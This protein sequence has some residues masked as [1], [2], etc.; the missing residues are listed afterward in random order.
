[1]KFTR[2]VALLVAALTPVTVLAQTSAPAVV[3]PRTFSWSS[4]A[5]PETIFWPAT[6]WW[7][8]G[9]L[10][11]DV[12]RRQLADMK[13]HDIRN[14]LMFP[15][16][17]DFRPGD[18]H[19]NPDYLTPEF[20]NRV[21]IVIGEATR[22]G[23]KLWAFVD[24]A[25]PPGFALRHHPQYA[26]QYATVQMVYNNG[27]W[28]ERR[29]P[30][31]YV[32]ADLLSPQTT[33]AFQAVTH[34]PYVNIAGS[35]FGS[36]LQF[37]FTD[38]PAYEYVK[39]GQSI[40]WTSGGDATFQRRFGYSALADG[41]LDAFTVTDVKKLTAAQKKVRGDVFDFLSGQFRD[42]YF[43]RERD[44]CR[45]N[46]GALCGHMGGE[47]VT[48][49]AAHF[50]YGSVMRQLR[51][52]DMPGVDA[53][54]RDIFPGQK[55]ENNFP[56][57]A[58]S[59]AHQN[60][61]ALSFTESFAVYG[62]GLT[63]AQM[64]W[65]LDY[66]FVRGINRY[67]AS[68]YPITTQDNAMTG[69]RPR[70]GPVEPMWDYLPAFH[71]YTARLGYTLAC[72]QPK[73]DIGLYYPVR[74]IWANG[75]ASDPAVR[76]FN[77]LTQALLE[78]QCDYDMIDDDILG[79]PATRVENGRLMLGA[80]SYRT[81]VV[82]PTAWM[83]DAAKQR[84]AA[85]E[86]AG[87]QVV[88]INDVDQINTAIAA[89]TPTIELSTASAD[90]R[91]AERCWTGGGAVFLFNEGQ[92]PYQG[93]VTVGLVG[94]LYL[95][96]PPTG[97][98]RSLNHT[99][100]PDGRAA[101]PLSLAAGESMLLVAQPAQ[102]TPA[103]SAPPIASAVVQSVTLT[104]GWTAHVDRQ[105]VVGEHDFE[106]HERESPQFQPVALGRWA[107]T[108]GLG[109]DFSGHVTYRRTVSVPEAMRGGR[110][111]LDLG[112]FEYAA[113]VLIDGK[114][115]GCVLWSPWTIELPSLGDR[116]EF[117]LDIQMSN[118][119]ANEITSQRVRDAWSQKTGP[120]WPTPYNE[121]ERNFE[122]ESRGGGLLGPVRLELVVPIAF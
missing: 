100:L 101:V 80:M 102:D 13:A 96:D 77:T 24:G 119:L 43:L 48:M 109:A 83:T 103:D 40:P 8:N 110:L 26:T 64:K 62:S 10:D 9:T 104:D 115:I 3:A 17:N 54:W 49:G 44:W 45:Q 7:W 122:A 18:Y 118:T 34:Q 37:M 1:M 72:G 121:R 81:I 31:A 88:R 95:L 16:L 15:L 47:N 50:G 41:N 120:G 90:I 113:R 114:E 59:V 98:T 71:R 27:S 111:R 5:N 79:D 70:F 22:L 55:T 35:Q 97:V 32:N 63:P 78:Q 86:A 75:D 30:S 105:Y 4:V 58:S 2:T 60:G 38:E 74:D 84:L 29:N 112:E 69:E 25:W 51:A 65:V 28:T 73:I 87:G 36:T 23:I 21:Q 53:I 42:A 116:A 92:A 39:L 14:A 89:I 82:G 52:M 76:G 56:K 57:F 6:I 46:N 11:P 67:L 93:T 94:K 107:A 19:M 61:T 106:I 85:F 20:S 91:V 99:R 117:V 66:Q 33:Q 12:L 108:L 68:N